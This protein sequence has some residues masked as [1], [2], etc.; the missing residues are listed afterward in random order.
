MFFVVIL[1]YILERDL[2]KHWRHLE[3]TVTEGIDELGSM[4]GTEIT[5]GQAT[6]PKVPEQTG[7]NKQ[8]LDVVTI[9]FPEILPLRETHLATRKK[10][11][12]ER[13]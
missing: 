5:S 12:S 9:K 3:V 8:L 4:Q 13:C 10:L 11:V 6:C 7:L 2:D 1:A